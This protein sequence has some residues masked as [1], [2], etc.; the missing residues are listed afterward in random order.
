MHKGIMIAGTHSGAGKTTACIGIMG[1]LSRRYVVQPFKVGPDYIDTSYH[2]YA[3]GKYSCNLDIYMQSRENIL[4]IFI[5]NAFRADISI[6]EGVMGLYDGM[7]S[8]SNGS[9]ADIA[10][11]LDIPVI[12]VVDAGAMSASVSAMVMGYMQYDKNVNIVGVI[13]NRVGS[14][15]HFRLLKECI[16]RDLKLNVFG[17]LPYNKDFRLP[18]RHLGLIPAFEMEGLNKKLEDLYDCVEENIDIDRI[19]ESA[20]DIDCCG[21]GGNTGV[22]VINKRV[23]IAYAYDEAFN[24]YY[25]NTMDVF[26]ESGA[27]LVPFSP[28]HDSSLPAGISGVYIGGGFPE[29][30]AERLSNN[31]GM[32][33]SIRN[34]VESGMAVYAECGGFMYLT[35]S[36]TCKD[37]SKYPM[38]GIYNVDTIMTDRLNHFGYVKVDVIEDNVLFNK[39]E[40]IR[41]HEF[42]YSK[43]SGGYPCMSYLVHK[44]GGNEA[45][46]CGYRYKNCLGTYVHIDL[47]AYPTAVKKFINYIKDSNV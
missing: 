31:I 41:G 44:L 25:K 23:K 24:F 36:I 15:R 38:A 5:K 18:E 4:S 10:K 16:E 32:M 22:S 2:R 26:M 43:V 30:F 19:L 47:S 6:V 40:T 17:Y 11:L 7:D 28:I 27:E 29:V 33:E 42:H 35:R 8:T 12:L 46:P 14:E 39:G 34:A 3:T 45:W 13:L 1:A 21:D 9:S 37:G 20:V